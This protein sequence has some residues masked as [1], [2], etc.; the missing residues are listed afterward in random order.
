[1][2]SLVIALFAVTL[3]CPF[4]Y[5][6]ETGRGNYT[7][8]I[9][10]LTEILNENECFYHTHNFEGREDPYGVGLDIIVFETQDNNF[11]I[12]LQGKYDMENEEKSAYIVGKVNL[13]D[14]LTKK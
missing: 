9:P 13:W 7:T 3:I 1:M 5:A 6:D 14:I 11:A 12:E 2:K 10:Q 8:P 4:V